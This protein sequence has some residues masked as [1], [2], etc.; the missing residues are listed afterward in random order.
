MKTPRPGIFSGL[1]VSAM[2]MAALLGILY[3]GWKVAGLPFVPF[4]TFDWFTRVLPGRVI[5]FGIGT[6]VTVIRSLNLGPT[7]ATAKM[8]EQAMA[9]VGLFVTG[10]VGGAILFAILRTT[11]RL[12]GI[13]L[14][15]ALG[16]A[17]G[18]PVM[19]VTLQRSETASVGP[20]ARAVWVLAAFLV[21]GMVLGRA[22]QRLM[23]ARGINSGPEVVAAREP[24]V[25]RIDRRRFLVRLG[26]TTA[27][28]TV[29]GAVLGELAEAMRQEAVM[30]A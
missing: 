13:T 22:E 19:L 27:A 30:I 20:V 3:F 23:G 5:A 4:D 25:E 10:V 2:L 9:I 8:A 14:G 12:H 7:S 1:F 29:A 26:G 15:L 11:R 21:W 17:V 28:I 18:V 16:I 24:A 6:M